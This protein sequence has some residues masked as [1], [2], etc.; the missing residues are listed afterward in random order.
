MSQNDIVTLYDSTLRDGAQ[1]PGVD[2]T[3]EDKFAITQA[4]GEFGID[5]IE[6]GM[7]GANPLDDDY[8]K[9][10]SKPSNSSISA[11]GMTRRAGITPD[12]DKNLRHLNECSADVLCL[13]GKASSFQVKDVL[14]IEEKENLAMI[15]E[16]FS[17][18]HK[19]DGARSLF[20]DAEHFFDGFKANSSYSM[21]CLARAAQGG[22]SALILCDTNGGSLPHEIFAITEKVVKE[23]APLMIGIHTHD[24]SGVAVANSLAAVRA[25][26]RQIQGTFNGLGERCGNANLVTILPSLIFKMGMATNIASDSLR[27][28]TSLAAQI[29]DLLNRTPQERAPYVGRQSFAHKGGLHGSG[30]AR[31][32]ASYE[33]IDPQL[34]GNMREMIVSHQAGGALIRHRLQQAGIPLGS[35]KEL[36]NLSETLKKKE[37]EGYAYD[38]AQASFDLLAH[39]CFGS[40][41]TFYE[42][43]KYHVSDGRIQQKDDTWTIESKAELQI[44]CGGQLHKTQEEGNGPVNALDKALRKA[45][46]PLFPVLS[47]VSLEDYK[48]RILNPRAHTQALIRVRIG[49]RD[50]G[51]LHWGCVG[52]STNVID[53]SFQ[54]LNDA[55]IWKLIKEQGS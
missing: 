42:V 14:C 36:K 21:S 49:C 31:A 33:H 48:V 15:E 52:V 43:K 10:V 23:F 8:F 19:H 47:Q 5:Y 30:M 50:A 12:Q 7:P 13:V 18:L 46:I 20:F 32:Q 17:F 16:S 44:E 51:G 9:K 55:L 6:G 11:F 37:Y 40:L 29:D 35:D 4:L 41:P 24:D 3:L 25:G 2:L 28:L 1:T 45:L 38:G 39:Q 27:M 22:A 26:A 53:A 54:A 34:V